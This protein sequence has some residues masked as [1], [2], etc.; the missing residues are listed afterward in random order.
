MATIEDVAKRVGVSRQTVSRVINNSGYV[1]AGTRERVKRAIKELNYRPNMLAKALATRHSHTVAHVMTN[2][3]DPFH[4]LVNQ[5]FES[6]AFERGYTSMMC[7]AHSSQRE[8]DYID[9]FK[10]HCIGGVV[11]HHLAI[12]REQVEELKAAGVCCVLLDNETEIKNVSSIVT[13]N[14]SGGYMAAEYLL[15]KGHQKIACIH[16]PLTLQEFPG[17]P[18]EDGFQF[19]IWRQRTKGFQDALAEH[20]VEPAG[21]YQS[22]GRFQYAAEYAGRIVDQMLAGPEVPTALYCENDIMAISM[23]SKFQER[24]MRVPDDFALIGH[25]GLDL[26]SML[27]PYITTVSQPRYDMGIRSANLLIDQIEKKVGV[28]NEILLPQIVEGET[29]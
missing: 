27:H 9:M 15:K 26:C 29:T 7:D 19:N 21:L 17:M 18:Y 4:N 11:F 22:H 16:G 1:E 14:Y 6:V 28:K 24:G 3:S 2:I 20:G 8:R 25:D 13:D 12:S 23:L 10:D 5:G